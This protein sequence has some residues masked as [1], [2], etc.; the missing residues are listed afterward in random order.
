MMIRTMKKQI[1]PLIYLI[2]IILASQIII[3][4]EPT[5]QSNQIFLQ[6][7]YRE[8]ITAGT[9]YTYT[10]QV[11]PPDGISEV[12]NAIIKLDIYLTPTV[13]FYL[14]VNGQTCNNPSYLVHTTY[15]DSGI[16]SV[17]FDCSN[18]I[19]QSG[20]YNIT[21]KSVGANTG[22]SNGWL[23]LTYM[24]NPQGDMNVMGTEYFE[25]DDGTIFLLLKDADGV[26]IEDATC[27]LDI[28]YPQINP[29]TTHPE[30]INDGMMLYLEE[31]LYYY[32]FVAPEFAGLYMVNAFC[33]YV[34]N[35]NFYYSLESG[36]TP[37]RNVTSGTYTG[38]AFVLNDYQ[39]WLYTQCDS[40]GGATKV[41]EADYEWTI[42]TNI[43]RLD[44][45]YLGEANANAILSMYWYN[46]T[47]NTWVILPNTLTFKATAGS[48]VPSGVD[49]YISNNIPL[50]A[51]NLSSN[52]VKIRTRTSFGSTFKLFDNWITLRTTQLGGSI[53]ELKGSGEVHINSRPAGEEGT[54]YKVTSCD[55]FSDG[56]CGNFTNDA[57]FDLT[58]GEIEDYFDVLALSTR[59][60]AH[61]IYNTPFAVDC[62]ALCWV[63]L[64]NGTD[65]EEFTDYT[66]YS[67]PSFENCIITI[68]KDIITG[69]T[70]NFWL[71][72]DNY[73]T[74]EVEWTKEM[75][76]A[77]NYSL[78]KLCS[79]RN[80]TYE[81][82]ITET[83]IISND[84][85]TNFCHQAYDDQYWL[86]TFYEDSQYVTL[87]GEYTSYVQE[88]RWYK[89]TLI[90]RII[91]LQVELASPVNIYDLLKD[92]NT[93]VTNIY[94]QV[95]LTDQR[96]I[97]F[98]YNTNQTLQQ[99]FTEIINNYNLTSQQIQELYSYLQNMNL[100]LTLKCDNLQ[101]TLDSVYSTQNQTLQEII[102][103]N[104]TINQN[105]INTQTMI[106]SIN[107]TLLYHFNITDTKIDELQLN[108]T[109][110]LNNIHLNISAQLSQ[111]IDYLIYINQTTTETLTI[112]QQ[113]W[114]YIVSWLN[115]T[116]NTIEY[117]LDL[118]LNASNITTTPITL[119]A[120]HNAPCITGSDWIIEATVKGNYGQ[121]L[122]NQSVVCNIT[123]DFTN[124]TM[125]TYQ[126]EGY[127]G[128][129]MTCPS[130]TNWTWQI[131]CEKI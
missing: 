102:N 83:T 108:L 52:K 74:W 113:I 70:Y 1:I 80:F 104:Q 47:N 21:F 73:M 12:K 13:T 57:E 86:N 79:D 28:Y 69:T 107:D 58:E 75:A 65:W 130:P 68:Y 89:N 3:A 30:W 66:L 35:N 7:F 19:N 127:F 60:Q 43:S 82:P 11:N 109:N 97:D 5:Q 48:G 100:N 31:G 10:L 87:V 78:E 56:R 76:D 98:S 16:G 39:E 45:L 128:Y 117:K 59:S 101:N 91:W 44:F 27:T 25:G 72:M 9:N 96:I 23:D 103:I 61:I 88:M 120:T 123:T 119:T 29:N 90:D 33:R 118:L 77:T 55:G 116:I 15:M 49:E 131:D 85:I 71:K 53:Q 126:P 26:P 50:R 84:T 38:D 64:W 24:N 8:T 105:I 110:Q 129:R 37:I 112:A 94:A 4:T 46:W 81:V 122:D 111:I 20:T 32:D 106:T 93:T 67:Q 36:L 124:N 22:A 41:C 114:N 42:G 40:T 121:I 115:G 14:W 95:N 54:F 125:M 62:T 18:I 63:K 34:T 17:A 99:I 92:V 2:A 6:P 51:I